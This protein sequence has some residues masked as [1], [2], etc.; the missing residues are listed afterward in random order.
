MRSL[1]A[2]AAYGQWCREVE[3]DGRE[4]ELARVQRVGWLLLVEH[5][6]CRRRGKR[7]LVRARCVGVRR[8]QGW[9]GE[10]W[11]RNCGLGGSGFGLHLAVVGV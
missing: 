8:A 11:G 3:R 6:A 10:R 5:A 1:A 2:H 7:L 4:R 9:L